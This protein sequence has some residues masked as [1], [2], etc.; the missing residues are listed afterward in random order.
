MVFALQVLVDE[1]C[2]QLFQDPS[3]VLHLPLQAAH[4]E[5]C[6]VPTVPHGER[7]LSLQRADE[8]QQEM[9]LIQQLPE[10]SQSLLHVGRNLI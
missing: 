8:G 2:Q 9:L 7:A 4:D 3:G 10:Q 6:H 1:V 5:G